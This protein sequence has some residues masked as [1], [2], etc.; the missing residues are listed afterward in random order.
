SWFARYIGLAMFLA[1]TGAFFTLIYSP[2]KQLIEGTPSEIWPKSWTEK[3]SNNMPVKAM[4]VQCFIVIV[5]ILISSFGGE[6]SSVF[7]NYLILMGNVAMTIPYMFLSYAFIS[8]KKKKEIEK[9][10]EIYKST[11]VATFAAIVVTVTVGFANFFTIIQPAI[12]TKDYLATIFQLI[13]PIFFGSVAFI[14]YNKYEK[15]LKTNK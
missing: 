13:G 1:L 5:I 15:N 6:S 14:L 3:N 2:L 8:F 4:W 10:F 7:L 11:K 12:E 9:P